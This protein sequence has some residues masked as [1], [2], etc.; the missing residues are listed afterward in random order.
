MKSFTILFL[1]I[2]AFLNAMAE[3]II[4]VEFKRAGLDYR[5]SIHPGTNTLEYDETALKPDTRDLSP[6]AITAH[7]RTKS[8]DDVDTHQPVNG[9][10]SWWM[11]SGSPF[12]RPNFAAIDRNT[13]FNAESC[14]LQDVLHGLELILSLDEI[15]SIAEVKLACQLRLRVNGA[16]ADHKAGSK[17]APFPASLRQQLKERVVA[18]EKISKQ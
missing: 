17:W 10:S 4:T 5:V 9:Y 3:D 13:T 14:S 12:H 15:E 8:V 11:S 1:C 2:Q 16:E 18:R 7:F 6:R